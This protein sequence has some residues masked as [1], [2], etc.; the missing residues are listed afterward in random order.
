[1]VVGHT[2]PASRF[3][4]ANR[5][6]A[7]QDRQPVNA[8]RPKKVTNTTKAT[9]KIRPTAHSTCGRSGRPCEIGRISQLPPCPRHL[10]PR[11]T[12]DA[13]GDIPLGRRLLRLHLS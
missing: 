10:R 8:T 4:S 1:M 3:G 9:T 7:Y 5:H 2:K 11:L 13:D 12:K 6:P